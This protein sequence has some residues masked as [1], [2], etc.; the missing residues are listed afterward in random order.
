VKNEVIKM[1]VDTDTQWAYWDGVRTFEKEKHDYL[2]GQIGNSTGADKPNKKYY[3]PRVWIRKA[4]ESMASRVIVSCETLGS[5][6][7]Y[8]FEK[9]GA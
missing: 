6:R 7:K 5:A 9:I 8:D 2:R 1:N 3:D 4:E